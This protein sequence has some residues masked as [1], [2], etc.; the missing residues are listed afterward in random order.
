M[1]AICANGRSLF[2]RVMLAWLLVSAATLDLLAADSVETT[3]RVTI[4]SLE[5]RVEI[6]TGGTGRWVQIQK[7]DLY[8]SDRVRTGPN[9]R[10]TLLWSD[11]STVRLDQ[12]TEAEILPPHAA[13]A[14]S[15]LHLVKGILSFF[16]R[17]KPGHIR[18][19]TKG[20][21]AGVD[22]T[23]FVMA[24]DPSGD[25]ERTTLWV[26]DGRVRFGNDLG[27]LVR[28]NGQAA[29][30]EVGQ[31][32]VPI[33]GFV[34]NNVLQWAFYYP[35]VLDLDELGLGTN[36]QGVINESLAAYREGDLLTAL[37]KYPAG[38]ESAS[39][40][41][42][43]YYSAL[44][45]SVGQA[46]QAE[47]AL[48]AMRDAD[49]SGRLGRLS[50]ALRLLVAA[51]KRE[52]KPTTPSPEL[53][54]EFLAASYYEQSRALGDTSLRT[55]LE[56]ATRA[57]TNSQ[58]F[59][60]AWERV[61]ELEFSFG[62]TSRALEALNKSL[63]LAPRDAQALALHGFLL[64][65]QNRTREA[66]DKFGSA[67]AVDP[68]LANARLG[69]GLCRIRR[70]GV[71]SG[72]EDLLVAAAL[73]PQRA[74]LRSYLAKAYQA[75]WDPAR[76]QKE[77]S[78]AKALDPDDPT[79]WLYSALVDQQQ[80]RVNEAVRDLEKSIDLNEN[81]RL[82]RSDLLLDQDRAVRSVNLA[83]VYRDAGMFDLSVRE[84]SR[85][86]STDYG[87]FS[88]HL[89]LA[90]SYDEL[91]DPNRINLR[92]ETPAEAEYL[93]A[94]LLAPVAAGPLSQ[95]VSQQEYSS[96]F[97]RD[98]LGVTST[99][100]YLSR[101]AWTEQGAQFGIIGNSAYSLEAAY[102]SDPGQRPNEDFVELNLSA[103]F[104]QQLTPQDDLFVQAIWY[105]AE[106]GDRAQ[107]YDPTAPFP[108]GPNL[109]LRTR[110]NQDP[111]LELGY[112]H[113]WFP[114]MQTLVLGA[115]L[116]DRISVQNPAQISLLV[117]RTP[118]GLDS[119]EP[120][121]I[122][123]NYHSELNIYSAEVQQI[124]Q[125]RRHTT[126]IGAR[127]QTGD[128]D[129]SSLQVGPYGTINVGFIAPDS[130]TPVQNTNVVVDYQRLSF[131]GYHQWQIVD[132]LWVVAG[133]TY[134]HIEFP[135][136]FRAAP[137][138]NQEQTE[139][140]VSPK[141]GLIWTPWRNTILR[142]AYT[143]SL[144]GASIDQS[145]QLE[146]T[147]V[148]GFLQS[149]RSIL[150]ESIGGAEAGARFET[151]GVS[152]EEKLP[153]GTYLGATLE[154][155]H[156]QQE[157]SLGEFEY[158]F[159]GPF[160]TLGSTPEHQDFREG[161]L[162]LTFNQLVGDYWALGARY[163]LAHA[164]LEVNYPEVLPIVD[165]Q[166]PALLKGFRRQQ[167]LESTLHQLDLHATFNHPSG[168]FGEFQ[169]LW[170]DQ[171]NEGYVVPKPGDNFWQL[172]AFAGYRFAQR[173]AELTL[174]L[175]NLTD[176][177]YKLNPLTLY[178]ELP[179]ERTLLVRLRLSF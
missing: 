124:W 30:V 97:E 75:D 60:F 128:F 145:V 120:F 70:G 132:P 62:H 49:P 3:N 116:N 5:G 111:I 85:A 71:K 92:Y 10:A 28:T 158:N 78:L 72:R 147:Q 4:D 115:R 142:A 149:F 16:H 25:A 63:A 164:N 148:A 43:V 65:A 67:L 8:P 94:N 90:N 36:E 66:I 134:D 101:G 114:G 175:L 157:R 140:Q 58:Q 12:L 74:V 168:F 27:T 170:Y 172:N 87:N 163:R 29:S 173:R 154:W 125:Q 50:G 169:S 144:S 151:A 178:A 47:T 79:A 95:P 24:V 18:L 13:E 6:S 96:L 129:T 56:L 34:A 166:D 57:A 136:N 37:A 32:P 118:E 103:K 41:E 171:S 156:S 133:V 42:R 105:Q 152:L 99:T 82:F 17:D 35:A 93:V 102:R 91:R 31:A 137:I 109:G 54:S 112:R 20:A 55:S 11:H 113:E 68:G 135:R 179:R 15:G 80:S 40:A 88:A 14:Q 117:D 76:A 26:I 69:R 174:G 127:F 176:Q 77:L 86:V 107:Y 83:A 122:S 150:P 162:L 155:L 73:E 119:V 153:T 38:R 126:I 39:D 104:K 61:A 167:E 19:I 51:V 44:L 22:G 141:A 121:F 46:Q 123:Q 21:V 160:A 108:Q 1:D 165:S 143:R 52:T 161:S 138:S 48:A 7:N 64:A 98:R 9:S 159:S 23:E 110:E 130:T 146:P 59:A 139:D 81:R 106:G 33:A 2:F 100:E 45:L 53:S 177:D 84:A 131:Y 89:F